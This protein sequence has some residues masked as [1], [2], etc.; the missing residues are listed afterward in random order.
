MCTVVK[1]WPTVTI[2]HVAVVTAA[3]RTSAVAAVYST[4]D[5]VRQT[6][7][8]LMTSSSVTTR[9]ARAE[10]ASDRS[11]SRHVPATFVGAILG[12]HLA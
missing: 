12:T 4:I 10:N 1:A 5:L 7:S 3:R 8:G 6:S 11:V 2:S 9:A